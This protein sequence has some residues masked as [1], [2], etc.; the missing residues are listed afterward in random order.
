MLEH[1]TIP[2]QVFVSEVW[3]DSLSAEN[4][5]AVLEAGNKFSDA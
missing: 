1:F 3:F 4:Q 2:D 5:E